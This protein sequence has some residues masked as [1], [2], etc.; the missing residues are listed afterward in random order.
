MVLREL[1]IYPE[2]LKHFERSLNLEVGTENGW[3]AARFHM[4]EIYYKQKNYDTALALDKASEVELQ[5]SMLNIGID[6]NLSC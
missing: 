2:A 4:G 5:N 3:A 6:E 1:E